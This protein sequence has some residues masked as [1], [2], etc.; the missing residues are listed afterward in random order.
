[1]YLAFWAASRVGG[2]PGELN[3]ATGMSLE[4]VCSGTKGLSGA[5]GMAYPTSGG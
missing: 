2:L 5:M 3:P 4:P 1:M